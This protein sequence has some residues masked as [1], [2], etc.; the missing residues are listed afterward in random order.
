MY[1]FPK[2]VWAKIDRTVFSLMANYIVNTWLTYSLFNT[3]KYNSIALKT[4]LVQKYE[5]TFHLKLPLLKPKIFNTHWVIPNFPG[6]GGRTLF[7]AFNFF[8]IFYIHCKK[9]KNVQKKIKGR[10]TKRTT[11]LTLE[12]YFLKKKN[13]TRRSIFKSNKCQVC[14]YSWES[15]ILLCHGTYEFF[16]GLSVHRTYLGKCRT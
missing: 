16:I 1:F 5:K 8:S 2:E 12:K 14:Y 13:M 6:Q 11:F 3:Y 15:S 4:F 9:K 10:R 7:F